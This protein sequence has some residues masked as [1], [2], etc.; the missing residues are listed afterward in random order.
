M[1]DQVGLKPWILSLCSRTAKLFL[2]LKKF[3]LTQVNKDFRQ[4][5]IYKHLDKVSNFQK[6]IL[7]WNEIKIEL[8]C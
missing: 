3:W 5:F 1:Q 6:N 4:K 8:L 2:I 7:W